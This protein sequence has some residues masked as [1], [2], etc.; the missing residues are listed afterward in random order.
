MTKHRSKYAINGVADIIGH[1]KG[2]FVAIEVKSK[3]GRQSEEQKLFEFNIKKNG[4]HYLLA[5]SLEEVIGFF[6]ALE[7]THKK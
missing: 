5:R 3:N 1:Y 6:R 2:I 7:T 4:G